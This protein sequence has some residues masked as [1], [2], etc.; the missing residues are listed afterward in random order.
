[1][2][3][4]IISGAG[5]IAKSAMLKNNSRKIVLHPAVVFSTAVGRVIAVLYY[6]DFAR[7]ATGVENA[8]GNG[9]R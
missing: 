2:N 8:L 1:M 7:A 3:A 9:R 6:D 5:V 4:C